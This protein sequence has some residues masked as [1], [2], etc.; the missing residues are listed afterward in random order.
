[1]NYV[2]VGR[3]NSRPAQFLRAVAISSGEYFGPSFLEYERVLMPRDPLA[4]D[5]VEPISWH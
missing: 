5:L 2:I 3:V 1:M 4:A